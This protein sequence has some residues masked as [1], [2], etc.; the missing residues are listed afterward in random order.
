MDEKKQ[1]IPV[2]EGQY[3]VAVEWSSHG[4]RP[5]LIRADKVTARQIKTKRTHGSSHFIT[6]RALVV[7]AGDKDACEELRARLDM[8]ADSF[9]AERRGILDAFRIAVEPFERRR[10][11]ELNEARA[12]LREI[13]AAA[14][15]PSD[16]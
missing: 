4:M 8:A 13:V 14:V 3:A 12:K 7:F 9:K 15:E 10:D 16:A 2:A 6:D 5:S 1:S 11:A